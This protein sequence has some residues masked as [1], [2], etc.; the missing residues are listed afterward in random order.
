MII[1]GLWI[2][3]AFVADIGSFERENDRLRTASCQLEALCESQRASMASFMQTLNVSESR[4]LCRKSVPRFNFKCDRATQETEYVALRD[5]IYLVQDFGWKE[6]NFENWIGAICVDWTEHL[7]LCI[8]LNK[9]ETVPFLWQKRGFFFLFFFVFVFFFQLEAHA[10]HRG[11]CLP[12]YC[13]CSSGA[14]PATFILSRLITK[15]KVS[16]FPPD[17]SYLIKNWNCR[18]SFMGIE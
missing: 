11:K 14:V 9:A 1:I 6:Q 12:Q 15:H 18:T 2:G 10:P 4:A 16:V 17:E 13:L 7:K 5:L 3:L 8:P